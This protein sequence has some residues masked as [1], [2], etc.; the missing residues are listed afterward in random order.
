MQKTLVLCQM[1]YICIRQGFFFLYENDLLKCMS[2]Q[3]KVCRPAPD[4]LSQAM[5]EN[6]DRSV[7][8]GGQSP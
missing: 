1:K 2:E 7:L 5:A 3:E 6:A 4:Q 8:A